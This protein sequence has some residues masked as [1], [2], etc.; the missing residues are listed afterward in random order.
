MKRENVE[1]AQEIIA[2]IEKLNWE[3]IQLSRTEPRCFFKRYKYTIWNHWYEDTRLDKEFPMTDEDKNLLTD[4]R[5]KKVEELEKEL[6][7]L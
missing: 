4:L 6:E 5:K 3:I 7:D 1:K 2:K